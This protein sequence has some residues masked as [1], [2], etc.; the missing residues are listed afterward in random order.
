[1]TEQGARE[2]LTPVTVLFVDISGSTTL[3][4]QRGDTVAF[5]LTMACLE[6]VG[7]EIKAAGGRVLRQL[8]D[9]VL[10]IFET[11]L[12]AVRAAIEIQQAT[13]DPGC[14]LAREGVRVRSGVSTGLAVLHADDVY[15]DVAN[16]AARLVGKADAG[17]IFL[18]GSVYGSLPM[19]LRAQVQLIDQMLL[20]NRPDAVPVY[21]Y[22]PDSPLT[23]IRR[24]TRR[25]ASAATLELQHGDLLLVIGP[26][27]PR[28]SIGRD[29]E[30]DICVEDDAVSRTHAEITLRGDRFML[31]DRSTNGTYVYADNGPMLRLVRDELALTGVGRIVLGAEETSHP[32][33]YRVA[34]R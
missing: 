30:N 28:V 19:Q 12:Q 33:L 4:A 11:P 32:I 21:K 8:G 20:R 27:R 14:S 10:A 29:A 13:E 5:G 16:V 24:R 22:A 18:S 23:T 2:Q 34:A 17:E 3:Y 7:A 26:K 9:G 1:M 31:V 15:G 6:L 25:R